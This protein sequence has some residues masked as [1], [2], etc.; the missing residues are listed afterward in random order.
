[1]PDE[2]DRDPPEPIAPSAGASSAGVDDVFPLV[3]DLGQHL[4]DWSWEGTVGLEDKIERVAGGYDQ[5]V[6]TLVGAESAIIQMDSR[7]AILKGLPGIPPLAALSRLKA[8]LLDVEAGQYTPATAREH[9]REVAATSGV[10]PPL[11]RIFGVMMLSF[12]FAVS[13]VGTWEA[14]IVA[15]L[16]GVA[17]GIFLLVAER[18]IQPA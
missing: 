1:M 16:T 6:V 7:E 2:D 5:E 13:I 10:Y 4:L 15:F 11:L 9:L 18:S 17:S 12:G 8:W 14:C 3:T